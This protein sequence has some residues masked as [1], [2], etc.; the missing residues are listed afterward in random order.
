MA[1]Q[2]FLRHSAPMWPGGDSAINA[3]MLIVLTALALVSLAGALTVPD[4]AVDASG[5]WLSDRAMD[6]LDRLTLIGSIFAAIF[7]MTR[8]NDLRHRAQ[9]RDGALDRAAHAGRTWR[10]QSRRL[11]DG[12]SRSINTQ[13]DAWHLTSARSRRDGTL[14]ER[15]ILTGNR[16]SAPHL[17][18]QNPSASTDC[19]PQIRFDQPSRVVGMFSGG[20]FHRQRNNPV[21]GTNTP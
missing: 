14:A 1:T 8:L 11:L 9:D 17:R 15:R 7:V 18:G 10:N 2:V 20:S 3:K 4:V 19:L 21:G 16:C 12:L 5:D 6:F 13:C